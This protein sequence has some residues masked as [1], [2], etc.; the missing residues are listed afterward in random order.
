MNRPKADTLNKLVELIKPPITSGK[1]KK[2]KSHVYKYKQGK[3]V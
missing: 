3:K 2:K 1:K